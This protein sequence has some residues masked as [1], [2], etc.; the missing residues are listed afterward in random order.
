MKPLNLD[1][2]PCAPTSSNCVIWNGPDIAC[3]SLCRGD[4][5]TDVV[6]KLAT[7]L[8]AI[9]DTLN[10]DNY[11]LACLSLNG[12]PPKT[13]DELIQALIEKICSCCDVTP[14]TPDTPSTPGDVNL[15]V[16][17]AECFGITTQM[18]VTDYAVYLGEQICS[19]LDELSVI[20]DSITSLD[21][22]VTAL[23][24]AP[25]PVFVLPQFTIGCNIGSLISGSTEDIDEILEEFINA[26]WCPISTTLGS[27][28]SLIT[29]ISAQCIAPTDPSIANPG[30][31][32]VVSY[33]TYN[34]GTTI[35]DVIRNLWIALCDLR[36][37]E[38]DVVAG[39]GITVSS[40]NVAGLTTF[41]VNVAPPVPGVNQYL[42]ATGAVDIKTSPSPT[43]YHFPAGYGTLSYLNIT[44]S[45]IEIEVHAAFDS[46]K[47]DLIPS[48]AYSDWVDGAIITTSGGADTIQ[49][50][51]FGGRSSI[52]MSLAGGGIPGDNIQVNMIKNS[53]LFWRGTLPAGDSV[54]VKFKTDASAATGFLNRA[55]LYVKEI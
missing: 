43:L 15:F 29:A 32:M 4:T 5:V 27:N 35:A 22:R 12:C 44:G 25:A 30:A 52:V 53:A 45:D 49:Y 34:T 55:Q 6:Y 48:A 23:E 1:N 46:G 7:E 47:A 9:L 33:P 36:A 24:T 14:V 3:L 41:T 20:N 18:L 31:T 11:D 51:T 16:T 17:P 40:A 37:R 42:N 2:S 28:G 50:E 10:V 13:F 8:C 38:Y 54:S 19:I 39:S 26:V 21:G